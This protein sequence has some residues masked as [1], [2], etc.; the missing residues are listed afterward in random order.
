MDSVLE[1]VGGSVDK[2][3]WVTTLVDSLID[4]VENGNESRDEN[5]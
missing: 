3:F 4:E 1:V 2:G 5:E